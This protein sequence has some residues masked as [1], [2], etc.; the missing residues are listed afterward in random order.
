MA[1]QNGALGIG[2]ENETGTIEA[3]KRADMGILHADPTA[4]ISNTRKIKYGFDQEFN[5]SP[6]VFY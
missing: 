4:S 3:G 5:R 1:P 6:I 2:I